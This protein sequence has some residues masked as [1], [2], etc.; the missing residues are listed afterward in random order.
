L[1]EYTEEDVAFVNSLASAGQHLHLVFPPLPNVREFRSS[2]LADV[3]AVF[4]SVN[5]LNKPKL[6]DSTF[7][8][9][10]WYHLDY[11]G[12]E[13]ETAAFMRAM[14]ILRCELSR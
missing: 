6:L 12:R 4:R 5:Q 8:F 2:S 9:D 13:I 14:N 1:P 7:F 11:C 3:P 10:Q